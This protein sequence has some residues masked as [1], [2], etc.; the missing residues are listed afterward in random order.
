MRY[1]KLFIRHLLKLVGYRLI[2]LEI[3][4]RT[5][6]FE[7][8][9]RVFKIFEY[10][11][12]NHFDFNN[13]RSLTHH[14]KSQL[15]QD[16]F[17]LASLNFK[18]EGFF[19]EFG[20]TNGL[21]ISNTW[22][23]EKQFGWNGI[24]AEPSRNWHADLESNRLCFIEKKAVWS[25]SNNKMVFLETKEPEL[26]TLLEFKDYDV[27]HRKGLTY[28]VETISL[29]DLLEK[30][31]APRRIDYLSIDTEGSE[32][33]ILKSF[34]FDFYEF[35][36]ITVEHN[37]TEQRNKINELLIQ[38]GYTQVLSDFSEWDDWYILQKVRYNSNLPNLNND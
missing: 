31:N 3:F 33:E 18:K 4:E 30:Y 36:V 19:V 1:F 23:L 10:A 13:Y 5:L 14:S 2:R 35:S 29:M 27:N 32:F 6:I 38:K 25:D 9:H 20:S 12:V 26:S 17:V 15:T 7:K 22:L 28:E 11:N 8:Y 34:D 16:I 21:D 37:F 24:L